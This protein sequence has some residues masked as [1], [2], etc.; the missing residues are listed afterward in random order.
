MNK[1][2]RLTEVLSLSSD[3]WNRQKLIFVHRKIGDV[4]E[5]NLLEGAL[6]S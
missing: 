5:Q 6:L 1:F 2:R 4:A 3:N